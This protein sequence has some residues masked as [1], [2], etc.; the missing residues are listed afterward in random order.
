MYEVVYLGVR[1][2]AR[3]GGWGNDT[4]FF[5][6]LKPLFRSAEQF[7]CPEFTV[8]GLTAEASPQPPELTF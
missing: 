1:V 3:G 8:E 5:F 7:D 6:P 4:F 2:G